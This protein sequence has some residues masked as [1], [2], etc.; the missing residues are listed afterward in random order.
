MA[1]IRTARRSG[2][3]IRGGKAVRESLWVLLGG[4]ATTITGGTGSV[5]VNAPNA[6]LLALRPYTVVRSRGFIHVKSDQ[7]AAAEDQAIVIAQCVVS[8]QAV[9]IGVTAVPTPV[10][11]GG[12]DLFYMYQTLMA[13]HGAGTVDSE[14][15]QWVQ[16]DSRAM[17]R[18]DDDEQNILVLESHPAALTQG[19]ITRHT[20]RF[21][22]KLH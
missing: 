3:F 17:R 20:G 14:E 16:Y 2:R 22:I 1:N 7:A 13:S 21:L 19:T 8:D 5:L 15:G 4:S 18:V 11:D 10:T 12:S 9:D 6:A